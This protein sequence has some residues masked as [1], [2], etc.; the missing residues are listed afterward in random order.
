MDALT[1]SLVELGL[2]PE[3]PFSV[4]ALV[5]Q[6]VSVSDVLRAFRTLD[7]DDQQYILRLARELNGAKQ[8][9]I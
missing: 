9:A 3:R 6:P 7:D 2:D 5:S 4:L 8:S 1:E